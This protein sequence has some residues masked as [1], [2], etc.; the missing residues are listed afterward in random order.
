MAAA[1][2]KSVIWTFYANIKQTVK[3]HTS[4][5]TAVTNAV[6]ASIA[7]VFMN[8]LNLERK[9]VEGVKVSTF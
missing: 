5:F 4:N 3:T 2:L 8:T 7:C 6:A 9:K 1:F